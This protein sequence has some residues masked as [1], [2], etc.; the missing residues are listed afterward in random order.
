MTPRYP[1]R[2]PAVAYRV[3]PGGDLV[4]LHLDTGFYYSSG[5]VGA[6][7][8]ELCDGRRHERELAELVAAEYE[9]SQETAATDVL[10]FLE[11]LARE[12]LVRLDG[13]PLEE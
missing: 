4:L 8:W 9:V 5:A 12:G 13:R 6:R 10:D 7:V 1:Q 3:L 11:E 2:D